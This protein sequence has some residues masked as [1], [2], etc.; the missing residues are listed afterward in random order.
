MQLFLMHAIQFKGF[1]RMVTPSIMIVTASIPKYHYFCRHE[2]A[3]WL[4]Y[5]DMRCGYL[6]SMCIADIDPVCASCA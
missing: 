2:N 3:E 5:N 6:T 4:S 1:P